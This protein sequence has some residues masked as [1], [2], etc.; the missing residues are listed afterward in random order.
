MPVKTPYSQARIFH[1]VSDAD[2][3]QPLF[4]EA[5]SSGIDDALMG[6][7]LVSLRMSH[8]FGSHGSRGLL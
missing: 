1:Q 2:A 3:V 4:A 6:G 8:V 5:F 7:N